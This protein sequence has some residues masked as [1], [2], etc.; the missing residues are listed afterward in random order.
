MRILFLGYQK[1]SIIDFYKSKNYDLCIT[2]DKLTPE[3]IKDFEPDWIISYGYQ[4]IIRE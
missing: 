3:Q 2:N 1:N 4:H